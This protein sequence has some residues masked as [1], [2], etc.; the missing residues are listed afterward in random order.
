VRKIPPETTTLADMSKFCMKFGHV[1]L[2][3]IIKFVAT[4]CQIFRQKSTE[5]DFG[6]GSAP[7]PAWGAY[8]ATPD[9]VAGLRGPASKGNGRGKR[10]GMSVLDSPGG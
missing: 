7:D 10:E 8:S 9:P 4:R 3:K 6:W 1:I 5:F 2:R